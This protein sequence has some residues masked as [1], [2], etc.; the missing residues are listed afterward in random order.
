MIKYFGI[1]ILTFCSYACSA[2][3]TIIYDLDGTLTNPELRVAK[4]IINRPRK[5]VDWDGFSLAS[6]A[7]SPMYES[8]K[9]LRADYAAGYHIEIWTGRGSIAR[10][11]TIEWL[12]KYDVPYHKLN[13]KTS[14]DST[15]THLVKSA[16][17]KAFTK[18]NGNTIIRVYDDTECNWKAFPDVADIRIPIGGSLRPINKTKCGAE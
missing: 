11:I 16:W 14:G 13:M 1:L 5:D 15:A 8:I 7:D 10:D 18:K 3:E 4:Y 2:T 17:Y 6:S 9:Q 12:K